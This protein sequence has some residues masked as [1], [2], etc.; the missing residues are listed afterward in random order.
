MDQSILTHIY[1]F[2]VEALNSRVRAEQMKSLLDTCLEHAPGGQKIEVDSDLR[3][4]IIRSSETLDITSLKTALQPHGF[5]LKEE[6]TPIAQADQATN[7]P[8]IIKVCVDGMTCQ[9]CVLTRPTLLRLIDY[10]H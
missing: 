4:L 8:K 5:H 3:I 2:H 6:Q 7:E 10:L 9:S 1:R